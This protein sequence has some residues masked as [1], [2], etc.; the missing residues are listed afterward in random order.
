MTKSG[1]SNKG[2][3]LPNIKEGEVRAAGIVASPCSGQT[4]THAHHALGHRTYFAWPGVVYPA[5][6]QVWCCWQLLALLLQFTGWT[7]PG[8]VAA[9]AQLK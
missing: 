7:V 3:G 4:Y 9:T 5:A 2:G 1:R 6:H 8:C